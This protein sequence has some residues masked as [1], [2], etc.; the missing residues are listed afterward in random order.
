MRLPFREDALQIALYNSQS[1]FPQPLSEENVRT[2]T[3][4]EIGM[5]PSLPHPY[6]LEILMSKMTESATACDE[7]EGIWVQHN[8]TDILAM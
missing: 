4:N 6:P 1:L 3:F 2:E 5:I 8:G 7:K